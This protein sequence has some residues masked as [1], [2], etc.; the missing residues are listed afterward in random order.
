MPRSRRSF[1][2]ITYHTF[3]T[4]LWWVELGRYICSWVHLFGPRWG[5]RC[6]Y[7]YFN[8]PNV[9]LEACCYVFYLHTTGG[10]WVQSASHY[11]PIVCLSFMPK[12][13]NILIF[14][15]TPI[16]FKYLDSIPM[17][18]NY[19]SEFLICM[20]YNF[21]NHFQIIVTITRYSAIISCLKE[22][23]YL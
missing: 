12:G 20:R 17:T 3:C 5:S 21:M 1:T 23:F 2:V 13:Q 18:S 8:F 19:W 11:Q 4:R 10:S 14:I 22:Q 7:D 6:I 9:S 16:N 15:R